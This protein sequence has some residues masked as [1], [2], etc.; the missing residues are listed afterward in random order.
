MPT[1]RQR[2]EGASKAHMPVLEV[3]RELLLVVEAVGLPRGEGSSSGGRKRPIE[4]RGLS[5]QAQ[6]GVIV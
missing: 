4:R 6:V 1:D 3:A 5:I 2:K